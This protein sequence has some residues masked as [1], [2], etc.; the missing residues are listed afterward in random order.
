[1]VTFS[2]VIEFDAYVCVDNITQ[3]FLCACLGVYIKVVE[4][5]FLLINSSNFELVDIY[6]LEYQC[7]WLLFSPSL[8]KF[9]VIFIESDRS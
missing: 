1:M 6:L 5:I 3:L 2:L 9:P 4:F 8:C 7:G